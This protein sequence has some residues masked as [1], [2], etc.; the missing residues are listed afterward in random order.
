[1]IDLLIRN[2]GHLYIRA[3]EEIWGSAWLAI[4]DGRVHSYGG[5]TVPE[6]AARD[7]VD[8]GGRPVTP[9]LINTH[10]HMF[11]NLTRSF[12]GAVNGSLFEWLTTLYPMWARL[13]QESAYESTWIAIAELL[14]GGCTT[15]MDHG[16]VHP[17]PG[18][19]DAQIAAARDI[20]FRFYPTRGSMS[21]SQDDG[22]LPPR[23]VVQDADTILEDSER[24]IRDFH[25]RLPG[26]T[27]RIGLAPCAPFTVGDDIMRETAALAER[28][29]VRL[30]THL[31][32]DRDEEAFCRENYG[33]SPVEHFEDLGWATDRTW[34]A[35]F[36]YPTDAEAQRLAAAGVGVS[37]CPSSNMLICGAAAKVQQLRAWGMPVGIGCDGSAST[38][39]ASLW[40]EARTAL[41]LGRFF[42]GPQ[43]MT[44]RDALDVATI[45]SARCLGWEDE[46]GHLAVGALADLVAW[47]IHPIALAGAL[48][49]P[50]E[51]LLRCGPGRAWTTIV[52]GRVLVDSGEL[53]LTGVDEHLARHTRLATAMQ[54]TR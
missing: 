29:S 49:D 34:V 47:D 6:P 5:A 27:I 10:H 40:L 35:H 13:D 8:V 39:H 1:M 52:G 42:G 3:G 17:R 24:L 53:R 14:L 4:H 31:A 2:A 43:A 37:H 21:R 45:G 12:G 46:I 32:E 54:A 48:T 44:S 7:T 36:A 26:A 33:R 20:G 16:Y 41:L 25:D 22:F 23:E 28:H 50:V 18:L 19:V 9:G 15:S 51:A 30:H 11:Q 38:D